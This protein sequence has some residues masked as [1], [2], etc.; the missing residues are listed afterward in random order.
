MNLLNSF[1]GLS[2]STNGEEFKID[3]A[4]GRDSVYQRTVFTV[5]DIC[6]K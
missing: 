3:S 2:E 5:G 6:K 4:A 1:V